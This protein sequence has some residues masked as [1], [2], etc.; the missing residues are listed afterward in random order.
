MT[1]WTW[2]CIE[3]CNLLKSA[4]TRYLWEI[5]IMDSELVPMPNGEDEADDSWVRFLT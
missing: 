4:K 3:R 5:Q 2:R 1:N